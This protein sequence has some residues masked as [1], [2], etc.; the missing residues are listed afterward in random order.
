MVPGPYD[1]NLGGDNWVADAAIKVIQNEDWSAMHLNFSG[2]DK[3]GHM[4][5]GGSVDKI[6]TYKWDPDT[7]M[8]QVHMPWIAKN[9]DVQLGKVIRALK[10]EG[11]W[12]STLFVVLADHGATDAKNA[13]F[14][15][16]AGG[17]N[18][19][20]YY[21][22][23]GTCANTTYGRTGAN[24]EVRSGASERDRQPRLQLSVHGHRGLA[25]RR[26]L[27]EEG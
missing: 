21:D 2:I 9:A 24:N 4:W 17:G 1:T 8:A 27:G 26:R 10:A 23:N 16:A 6:A 7:I 18:L 3:I 5:G 22:P 11:D 19:S 15:D 12:N 14:V 20:W 13:H 25:H